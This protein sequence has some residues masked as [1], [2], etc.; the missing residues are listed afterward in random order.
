[1]CVQPGAVP[2]QPANCKLVQ[3]RH[4]RCCYFRS[5]IKPA[6]SLRYLQQTFAAVH[7]Q[8]A[9][10]CRSLAGNRAMTHSWLATLRRPIGTTQTPSQRS[11][12]EGRLTNTSC[13]ATGRDGVPMLMADA[14][15]E[16]SSAE[17]IQSQIRFVDMAF[18]LPAATQGCC[19]IE[20]R[21]C[22]GRARG[23]RGGTAETSQVS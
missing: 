4:L 19:T 17:R 23:C 8:I 9:L 11:R 15:C 22:T 13:T 2:K 12:G 10:K 5:M 6:V 7:E 3:T 21:Q 16:H 18:P 14:R 20:A 1:M